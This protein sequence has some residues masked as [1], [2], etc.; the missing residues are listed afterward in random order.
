MGSFN[1]L[2]CKNVG[3][4]TTPEERYKHSQRMLEAK[5]A[6]RAEQGAIVFDE[7]RLPDT[8]ISQ[9]TN[10]KAPSGTDVRLPTALEVFGGPI[11]KLARE[12]VSQQPDAAG[13][14]YDEREYRENIESRNLRIEYYERI[15]HFDKAT[16]W[17]AQL[18]RV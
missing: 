11:A 13:L 10:A 14:S 5:A 17:D 6:K 15:G 1:A 7:P 18:A 9:L 3:D 2:V 8:R 16:L 12:R 4:R